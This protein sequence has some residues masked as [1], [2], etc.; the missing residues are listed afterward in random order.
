MVAAIAAIAVAH[1]AAGAGMAQDA[2]KQIKLS[3]KQVQGFIASYKAMSD[4]GKS[5]KADA[6]VDEAKLEAVAKQHGFASLGEYD[7][8]ATNILMVMDGI[9]PKTKAFTEPPEQIKGRIEA[10][11]A[12]KSIAPKE[13][14]EMLADLAEAA[15]TAR[16]V[17]FREN[18]DLVKKHWDKLDALLQ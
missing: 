3:E 10:I 12:D 17:Q 16:P 5:D 18:I 2:A 13:R 4:A 15:K 6:K 11:K 9:D 1:F 7:D 14:D 8:V